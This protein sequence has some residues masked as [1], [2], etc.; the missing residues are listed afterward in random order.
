MTEYNEQQPLLTTEIEN[1]QLRIFQHLNEILGIENVYLE[2][3]EINI[4]ATPKRENR[5]N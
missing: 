3:N 1:E 2:C 4:N 5:N